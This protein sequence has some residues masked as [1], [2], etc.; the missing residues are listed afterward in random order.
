VEG[1][2]A[3]YT[4]EVVEKIREQVQKVVIEQDEMLDLCL[5]A[6]LSGGHVLLEGVPGLAKTLL[7]RTLAKT[8]HL[9]FKRVQFTTD[10][11][12]AELTGTQIYNMQSGIFELKKG[13]IFTNFF[14]ADEINRTPPKT[15]AGLLEAMEEQ[16]VT[17]DGKKHVLS[18][19]YIVFATQN[20]IEYEG[21]YPLPEALLDRFFMKLMVKYPSQQAEKDVLKRYDRGFRS[22]DLENAGIGVVCS[23]EDIKNCQKEIEAVRVDDDLLGYM[24]NIVTMTRNHPV[25][26]IGSSPRGS[27]ALLLAAKTYA[28]MQG[29]G[30]VIPDDIKE[31]AVPILRHRMTLK[32]EAEMEGMTTDQAIGN[33]LSQVKVPR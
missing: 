22:V 20:P 10:L 27:I 6:V 12:P 21:T 1:I 3:G 14:L 15:Q 13:P 24:I 18:N 19:P 26:E 11:M 29:R 5:V 31:M 32:P 33:I 30:Y 9:Q 2:N 4:K 23:E 28:V 16:S 17:I 7:V 8:I 25:I